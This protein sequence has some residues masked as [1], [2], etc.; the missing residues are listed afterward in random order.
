M[1]FPALT[2]ICLAPLD[3][4]TKLKTLKS[5]AEDGYVISRAAWTKARKTFTIKYNDMSTTDYNTLLSFF[6]VNAKGG[7]EIFNW[8]HPITSVIYE[9]RFK[10]DILNVSYMTS[11]FVNCSFVLEEV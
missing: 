4:S 5:P 8:T 3:E 1:N 9:V 6:T 2:A 10:E 11:S 7:T